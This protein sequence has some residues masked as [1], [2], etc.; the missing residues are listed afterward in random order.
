VGVPE[1]VKLLR[2]GWILDNKDVDTIVM[3]SLTAFG[4]QAA[5]SRP[6]AADDEA[7][8]NSLTSLAAVGYQLGRLLLGSSERPALY[9]WQSESAAGEKDHLE[10]RSRSYDAAELFQLAGPSLEA[11]LTWLREHGKRPGGM[12]FVADDVAVGYFTLAVGTGLA[13]AVSEADLHGVS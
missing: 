4:R 11:L 10:E 3:A 1:L 5:T 6:L 12:A 8:C 7:T 2:E 9:S 13:L